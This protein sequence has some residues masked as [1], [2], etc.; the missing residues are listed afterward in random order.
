[1]IRVLA[2][3]LLLAHGWVNI[4]VW[5]ARPR[6]GGEPPFDPGHSWALASAGVPDHRARSTAK[7]LAVLTGVLGIAAGAALIAGAGW[8]AP[9]AAVSAGCGL[10]LKLLWFNPW[11]LLGVALDAGILL[12]VALGWPASLY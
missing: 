1:M 4:Q 12:A 2:V 11:L 9:V 5:V 7:A 10:V 8:W 6:P 3:I